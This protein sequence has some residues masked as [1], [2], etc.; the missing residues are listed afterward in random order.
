MRLCQVTSWFR[1]WTSRL[2]HAV[3]IEAPVAAAWPWLVQ[4]GYGRAGWYTDAW[5]YRQVDRYLW[6]VETPRPDRIVPEWQRLAV[7]TIGHDGPPGTASF[8][9]TMLDPPRPLALYSTTHATVWLPHALRENPRV[10]LHGELSWVFVLH[11][12]PPAR[13]RLLLRTR[14]AVGLALYR[15]IATMLLPPA[16]LFVARMMLL[17]IRQRVERAAARRALTQM[18]A[19]GEVEAVTG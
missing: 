9:V 19:R 8:T 18:H 2:P 17:H 13:T 12:L 11:E 6:H 1:A 7:G 4:M 14:V 15:G 10:G 16:D 3:T 5:W